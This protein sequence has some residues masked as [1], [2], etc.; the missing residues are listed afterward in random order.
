MICRIDIVAPT[1]ALEPSGSLPVGTAEDIDTAKAE[2]KSGWQALKA[3]TTP[4]Q[5]VK[6]YRATNI[7]GED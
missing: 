7:K 3:R 6:A 2:F 4:E 5:L 1:T